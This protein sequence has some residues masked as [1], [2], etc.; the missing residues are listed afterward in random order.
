MQFVTSL[1]E[2][3]LQSFSVRVANVHMMY[4]VRK[5]KEEEFVIPAEARKCPQRIR[6]WSGTV[7]NGV[8][9]NVEL[10]AAVYGFQPASQ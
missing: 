8:W 7:V 10:T 6:L 3:L 2:D 9:A 1:L 5:G 4:V